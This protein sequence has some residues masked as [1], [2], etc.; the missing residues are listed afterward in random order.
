M[1][2]NGFIIEIKNDSTAKGREWANFLTVNR[3]R[4][5]RINADFLIRRRRAYGGRAPHRG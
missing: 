2:E 4:V 3:R 5:T 1:P